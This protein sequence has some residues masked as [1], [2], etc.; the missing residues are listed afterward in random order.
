MAGQYPIYGM[1]RID[2][3]FLPGA[4]YTWIR[5]EGNLCKTYG[6]PNKHG[7]AKQV[8][9]SFMKQ[10][11]EDVVENRSILILP[12]HDAAL[13][14]EE[15]PRRVMEKRR[16]EGKLTHFDEY[17]ADGKGYNLIYRFKKN[18]KCFKWRV[19]IGASL[20]G[21]LTDLINQGK[22]YYKEVLKW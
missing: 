12:I 11:L 10:V 4:D 19:I 2:D 15:I 9:H 14:V 21:T 16:K 1:A 3:V 8:F 5:G 13:M 22:R 20:Y 7:L 6:T 18:G 17:D